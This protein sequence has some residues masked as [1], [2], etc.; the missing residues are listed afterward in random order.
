MKR[1]FTVSGLLLFAALYIKA[2]DKNLKLHYVFDNSKNDVITD[3][4]GNGY[5]GKL[6]NNAVVKKMGKYNV[7]DLGANDGYLDMGTKTGDLITS[8]GDFSIATYLWVYPDA[9]VRANGNFVF[10]FASD[11]KCS[12]TKGQ[13]VAYKV[14][15]Q[16]YEQSLAG[17]KNELVGVEVKKPAEKGV[18]M[19]IVYSQSGKTGTLYVNGKVVA[20]SDAPLQPKDIDSPT[21]YNWLGKAPFPGDINLKAMYSDFRIYDRSLNSDEIRKLGNDLDGLNAVK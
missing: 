4:T 13:F 8:L 21:L 7:L 11:E 5:D 19:H 14:N 3:Q 10:A 1:K 12:E 18:W 6:V 17:W 20:T 9:N 15:I 16:R 2:A